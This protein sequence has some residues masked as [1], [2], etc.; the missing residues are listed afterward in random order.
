MINCGSTVG[1]AVQTAGE[2]DDTSQAC[3]EAGFSHCCISSMDMGHASLDDHLDFA[4]RWL[5]ML[6]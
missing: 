4:T 3:R 2:A 5:Q 1:G 6:R